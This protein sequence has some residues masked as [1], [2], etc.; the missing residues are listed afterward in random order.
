MEKAKTALG[1]M[2]CFVKLITDITIISMP[3]NRNLIL[4]LS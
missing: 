1:G 4:W 2:I 3:H